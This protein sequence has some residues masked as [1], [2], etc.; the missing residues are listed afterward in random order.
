MCCSV[1]RNYMIHLRSSLVELMGGSR[2]EAD[3]DFVRLAWAI[4][5]VGQWLAG[6]QELAPA[7]A[8]A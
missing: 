7:E 5:G 2:Y 4:R 8:P 1:K 6:S 3:L